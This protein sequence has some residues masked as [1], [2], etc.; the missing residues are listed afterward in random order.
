[1]PWISK[2]VYPVYLTERPQLNITTLVEKT[3]HF[4]SSD[5]AYNTPS[6][7]SRLNFKPRSSSRISS[8]FLCSAMKY[9]T[10]R[11]FQSLAVYCIQ[12]PDHKRQ[13]EIT[14]LDDTMLLNNVRTLALQPVWYE[15]LFVTAA[16]RYMLFND[17][18]CT[19]YCAWFVSNASFCGYGKAWRLSEVRLGFRYNQNI[20]FE[21]CR[22]LLYSVIWIFEIVRN[23]T[24]W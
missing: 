4:S 1:M 12:W 23:I 19:V 17:L 18:L 11:L 6:V 24:W 9:V 10:T 20:S 8:H 15:C 13:S 5:S 3:E 7:S 16:N 14:D 2:S 22:I 21:C